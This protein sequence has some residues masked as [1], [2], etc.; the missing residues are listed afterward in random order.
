MWTKAEHNRA[1]TKVNAVETLSLEILFRRYLRDVHRFVAHQMGPGANESDI[2]D[3]TQRVFIEAGKGL[4][5]FRGDSKPSTWLY[6]IASREVLGHLRSRKR[7]RILIERLEARL[8]Q[9]KAGDDLE[10]RLETQQELDRVWRCLMRI[11]PKKRMAFVMHR[12]EGKSGKE[13]AEILQIKE[14]TVWTRIHHARSELL[15]RLERERAG[16]RQ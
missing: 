1:G 10:A 4:P 3:L 16:E 14:A 5:G 9:H 2:E 15:T 8:Q 13:I 12:V 11:K 7:H 6:R